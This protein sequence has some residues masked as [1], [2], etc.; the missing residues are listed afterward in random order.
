MPIRKR[1]N[2]S[3]I[4]TDILI[5]NQKHVKSSIFYKLLDIIIYIKFK[6]LHTLYDHK[7]YEKI[8]QKEIK[9]KEMH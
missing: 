8:I 6:L 1:S 7:I 2:Y 4:Y 5:T 9:F 3:T